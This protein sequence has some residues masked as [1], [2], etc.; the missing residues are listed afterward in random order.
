MK[1]S[2]PSLSLI[3]ECAQILFDYFEEQA[4]TNKARQDPYVLTGP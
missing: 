2:I 4:L 3:K 1:S